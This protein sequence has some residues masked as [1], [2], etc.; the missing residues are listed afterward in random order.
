RVLGALEV[1]VDGRVRDIPAG[2]QRAVLCRLLVS[3]GHPVSADA[4]IEAAWRSGRPDDPARAL[5][6]VLSRLRAHLGRDVIETGPEGDGLCVAPGAVDAKEFMEL[7]ESA[8]AADPAHARELLGR[9]LALWRG[10]GYG[11]YSDAPFATGAAHRLAQ[12][13]WDAVEMYASTLIET[14]EPSAAVAGLEQL[15]ADEP[16]RERAV[17]LLAAALYHAGRQAE[18][19]QQLR[20]FRA[21][22]GAE[23]GL[24]PSPGLTSLERRI[25]GHDVAPAG[26][27]S[28]GPPPWLET[29]TAFIGR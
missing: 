20:D 5:R 12:L 7:V 14:G 3:A 10:P 28:A 21:L 4:L 9:A 6:T 27:A 23:L 13:R 17:A 22:L 16:F 19:L 18:A 29:S 2:R 1:Q 24:D 15:L 26:P 11:E 8:R 25:L